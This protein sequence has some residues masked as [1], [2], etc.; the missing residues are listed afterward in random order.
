MSEIVKAFLSTLR[1]HTETHKHADIHKHTHR[2]THI[3]K[4]THEHKHK[5]ANFRKQVDYL[6]AQ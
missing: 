2:Y 1:R 5:L 3:Y 6:F 4:H